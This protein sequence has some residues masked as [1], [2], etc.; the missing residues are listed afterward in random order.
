ME[1]LTLPPV[2]NSACDFQL[3]NQGR[4]VHEGNVGF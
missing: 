3:L 2:E 1:E 4:R